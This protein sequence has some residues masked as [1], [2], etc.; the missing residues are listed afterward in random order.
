MLNGMTFK[1]SSELSRD[2]LW[3]IVGTNAFGI[4]EHSENFMQTANNSC[5]GDSL[6]KC[7]HRIARSVID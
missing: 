1:V 6:E 4:A 3:T 7:G 2:E 5:R